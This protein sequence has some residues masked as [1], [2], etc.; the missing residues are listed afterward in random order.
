MRIDQNVLE[1]IKRLNLP[2]IIQERG[3]QLHKNGGWFNRNNNSYKILCPFHDDKNPS[4][5]INHK[6]GKWIWHCFG[7]NEHGNTFDFLQKIDG[8]DFITTYEKYGKRYETK[9]EVQR[10]KAEEKPVAKHQP[11]AAINKQELLQR[12]IEHYHSNIIED[13]RATEYLKKRCIIDGEAIKTFKIGFSNGSLKQMMPVD[14]NNDIIVV[15]K[16]I[17]IINER[18]NERYHNSITIPI[19]DANNA[20]VGIYGRNITANTGTSY[21]SHLYL[22]GPHKGIFNWQAIKAHKEIILTECIIDALS[23]YVMGIKNTV[24]LYGINGLTEEHLKLFREHRTQKIHLCFDNDEPGRQARQRIKE[25]LLPLGITIND[26][27][28]PKEYKDTNDALCQGMT[29]QGFWKLENTQQQ[30]ISRPLSGGQTTS[31]GKS[32]KAEVEQ[33]ED[34]IYIKFRERQYRIKGLNLK[35]TEHMRVNVRIT[36]KENHHLDTFDLYSSKS[37]SIFISQCKKIMYIEEKD[38]TKEINQI[39]EELEQIQSQAI[40]NKEQEQ[41]KKPTMT[42]TEKQEAINAL[43]HPALLNNILKDMETVGYIGEKSNKTIG[44]LVSISRKLDDPLSCS[45]ISQ[46]SAGKSVLAD[47]VEKLTP[48]EDLLSLSR[49]TPSAFFYKDA[50]QHKLIIMEERVG[51]E[52]ADYAIRTLQS[53]KKLTQIVTIKDEKTGDIKAKTFEVQ[54]PVAYIETTTQIRI[55]DENATRCFEINIDESMEQTQRIHQ[56]QKQS[57]TLQSLETHTMTQKTIKLHH[58]M[59]RLLNPIKIIIPYALLID[60]PTHWLRTR[61]D[62][63]RFLNLITVITFLHQYQRPLKETHDGIPYIEAT[64]DDYKIAYHLACEI[65]GE[66]FHDLKK[67][68]RD[69]LQAMQQINLTPEGVTRRKIREHTGLA[70]TRLRELLYNLVS[71]EYLIPMEGKQGK[72]YRYKLTER[73]HQETKNIVGLTTPDEL[74]QKHQKI[75]TTSENLAIPSHI[76]ELRARGREEVCC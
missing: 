20:I 7:C 29:K 24:P 6:N 73:I 43:K 33:K 32:L 46:S 58:N 13:R 75:K 35:P 10:P 27:V 59:Q 52:N 9:C 28:L 64:L 2:E 30:T 50:L 66:S 17:G 4:L 31:E 49:A 47:T 1:S 36:Q 62:N 18:G 70:D 16:E 42:E 3:I 41:E 45:I 57:K 71:L 56:A 23:L 48:P 67:S 11:K 22:P 61:R 25:K 74:Q 37:R 51:I 19:Y 54:G 60:F 5:H 34:A 72:S 8:S 63:L 14:E 55:H 15:L 39:I 76:A 12:I 65:M 53:K 38:I 21:P 44:Y 40:G 69:L 68:Q 26:I